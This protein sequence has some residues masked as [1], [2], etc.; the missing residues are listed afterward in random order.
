MIAAYVGLGLPGAALGVAWP[1]M[2]AEVGRPLSSL[3]LLITA[4][5][6]GY[7]VATSVHGHTSTRVG[8]GALLVSASALAA[9]AAAGFATTST[10]GVL[11][12]A[13]VVLGV[14]GGAIDAVLNAHVA[15]Y[16]SARTMHLM[17]G[18]F[19]IGA[20][21]G[22]LLMTALIGVGLSW[23]WGFAA[24]AVLQAGLV[25]GFLV[26]R[27]QWPVSVAAPR[28][29]EPAGPRPVAAWLGP[30]VFLAYGAVEVGIGAWAYVLLTG[31]GLGDTAAGASVTAYWAALAAGRLALGALG[32]RVT[33]RQVVAGSVS[34]VAVGAFALWLLPAAA[35]PVGLVLLG[36]SL[37]GIF[38]ALTA[39]TPSRVGPERATSVIGRQL[40]AA[41]VGGAAGSAVI[42]IVAQHLGAEAVAPA[43]VAVGLLLVA[44]NATLTVAST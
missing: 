8:T 1:S 22:P 17:H 13:S 32:T 37:A 27:R 33:S 28:S 20:T 41:M 2:R 6:V 3:G 16:R 15:L 40:A 5:T 42:G 14:S 24:V 39:L 9:A 44:A 26:T 34:G 31:R 38:P 12:G 18:G 43:I 11:L 23:R 36:L 35:S 29:R 21:V 30:L 7:L 19:G 4:F 10:W 25:V